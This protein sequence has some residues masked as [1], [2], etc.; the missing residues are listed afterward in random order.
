MVDTFTSKRVEINGKRFF[1][2]PNTLTEIFGFGE[3][4]TRVQISGQSAQAIPAEDLT[5]RFGKVNFDILMVDS[6]SDSDPL[7]L[8]E[9]WKANNGKNLIKLL[10]DGAGKSRM[11]RF[12]SLKNDPEF[13]HSS[14]GVISLMWEASK[15]TIT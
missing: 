4:N 12:A 11:Y 1:Y 6:N 14:D 3:T 13:Q 2:V 5:S 9:A 15:G 7:T 8:I 10:P